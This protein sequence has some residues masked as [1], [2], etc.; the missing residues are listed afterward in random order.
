MIR[1]NLLP[2]R[3][4]RRR[5]APESGVAT[6]VLLVIA[7]LLASYFYYSLR[8]SRM[9]G[10]IEAITREITEIRPKVAEV[11][12]LQAKID[13]MRAREDLLKS[14]EA[15]QLPW[16]EVLFDL[17]DRTPQDVWLASVTFIPTPQ[18]L[19]T[20]QGNAFSYD[21]VGRFMT[22]L[23]GSRFYDGVDLQA[24]VESKAGSRPVVTFGLAVGV[25]PAEVVA[26]GGAR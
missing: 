17:V 14:L 25:R 16:A 3:R 18:T 24:A 1:I 13:E 10:E 6:V 26:Q 23:A 15:H 9:S 7:A 20:L 19:L 4:R 12:A 5:L 8:N 21:A 2:E 11:L 22:N